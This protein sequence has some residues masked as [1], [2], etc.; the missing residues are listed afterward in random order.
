MIASNVQDLTHSRPH[1]VRDVISDVMR[2]VVHYAPHGRPV[3]EWISQRMLSRTNV[4][5]TRRIQSNPRF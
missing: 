1:T 3:A 5:L 2:D 4:G